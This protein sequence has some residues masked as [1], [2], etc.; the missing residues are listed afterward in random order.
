MMLRD[1]VNCGQSLFHRVS[2]GGLRMIL[3][4]R[5]FG[6]TAQATPKTLSR[7]NGLYLPIFGG[8]KR[9]SHMRLIRSRPERR[10]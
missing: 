8:L 4:I 7:C 3:P 10:Q 9:Q 6:L 2:D 1:A 5:A